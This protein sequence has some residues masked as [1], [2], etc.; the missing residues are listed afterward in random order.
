MQQFQPASH[1]SMSV[2][3]PR[4]ISRARRVIRRRRVRSASYSARWRRCR[5]G[6]PACRS[7]AGQRRRQTRSP[8]PPVGLSRQ[9]MP[10]SRAVSD[11]PYPTSGVP[12]NG[13]ARLHL[14][15]VTERCG[16]PHRRSAPLNITPR[17]TDALPEVGR[18]RTSSVGLARVRSWTVAHITGQKDTEQRRVQEVPQEMRADR[19]AGA[20]RFVRHA[21]HQRDQEYPGAAT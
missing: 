16:R 11:S 19:N 21:H 4:T 7:C 15:A 5:S 18:T 13:A 12:V 20:H 2:A 10:T 8:P 17:S 9:P 14:L 6:A 1:P 3:W